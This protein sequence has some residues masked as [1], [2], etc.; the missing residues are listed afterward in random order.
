VLREEGGRADDSFTIV[1]QYDSSS[2]REDLVCTVKTTIV[3]TLP[4]ERQLKFMVRGREGTFL[5]VGIPQ[6]SRFWVDV[7]LTA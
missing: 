7:L 4:M 5:K 1:L 3:S 6:P 2:G